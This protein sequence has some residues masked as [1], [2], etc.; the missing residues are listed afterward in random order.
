[1][2]S[3]CLA[4]DSILNKALKTFYNTLYLP[5]WLSALCTGVNPFNPVL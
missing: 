5:S 1:M 2:K 4:V 3:F